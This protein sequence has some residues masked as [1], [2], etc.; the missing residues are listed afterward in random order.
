METQYEYGT[1]VRIW[2]VARF[3]EQRK[4]KAT[5]YA[6]GQSI[7]KPPNATRYLVQ[8]RHAISSH[9]Y[10]WIDHHAYHWQL[11]RSKL[12]RISRLSEISGQPPR[13][14]YVGIP[15]M[16][17]KG[18]VCHVFEQ[19]GF[20]LLYQCDSYSDELSYWTAHPLDPSKGLLMI[21]YTNDVNDNKFTPSPG[22]TNPRDWLEYCKVAFDVLYEEGCN[23]EP[24][25]MTIG[26]YSRLVG[27]P[28]RF[29]ALRELVN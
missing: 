20:E 13:G 14:W 27:R 10:R 1:P 18:L 9:G 16:S 25:M 24:K 8:S 2:R 7:L 5:V 21:P 15:S 3:L 11:A 6:V 28:A 4:I 19:Q 29:Q 17:S 23:S 22:F 26:L 12:R